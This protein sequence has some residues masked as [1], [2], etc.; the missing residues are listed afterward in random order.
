M[1]LDHISPLLFFAAGRLHIFSMGRSRDEPQW[2]ATGRMRI[3]ERFGTVGD[4]LSSAI[5][6]TSQNPL[7]GSDP[8]GAPLAT[9]Q[10]VR[11]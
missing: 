8:S 5:E 1:M 2:K 9:R 3:Y 11:A 7:R 6:A 4:P 10:P